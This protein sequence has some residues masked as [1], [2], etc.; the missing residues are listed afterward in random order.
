MADKDDAEKSKE[1]GKKGGKGKLLVLLPTILLLAGAGWY[2]FLRSD[3]PAEVVLPTP[4][5]GTVKTL[6]PITVN[7]AGG[8]FLKLGM[9]MQFDLSAG[10]ETDGSRALDLAIGQF[11]G[12]TID[13][14]ATTEG[15]TK[16]KEELIARVKLA[17][18]PETPEGETATQEALK[19]AV[20]ELPIE[21]PAAAAEETTAAADAAAAEETTSK[22]SMKIKKKKKV[23]HTTPAASGESEELEPTALSGEQAILA[24]SKLTVLPMAYD[25]YFTEFVMQ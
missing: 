22:K 25:L 10:E 24:A 18:M 4:T 9:A 20:D 14:L 11:S 12:K 19:A 21:E 1:E 8:H 5:A 13:E 7:L 16:A 15:R 2:F 3:A 23:M 6:D 17:Y